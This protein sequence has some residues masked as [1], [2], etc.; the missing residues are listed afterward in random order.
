MSEAIQ[1]LKLLQKRAEYVANQ[2]QT[3]MKD[4]FKP[5]TKETHG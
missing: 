3:N 5:Q 2:I 1:Y 4:E